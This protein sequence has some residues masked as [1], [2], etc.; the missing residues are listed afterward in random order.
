MSST[1][2]Q[3]SII[4][5]DDAIQFKREIIYYVQIEVMRMNINIVGLKFLW[6]F[7]WYNFTKWN[8]DWLDI[9]KVAFIGIYLK[10]SVKWEAYLSEMN[11]PKWTRTDCIT[12]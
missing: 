5:R 10:Y 2:K 4:W 3:Y 9:S 12:P 6:A 1:M 8:S 11:D 7:S